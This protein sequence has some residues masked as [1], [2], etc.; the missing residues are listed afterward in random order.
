MVWLVSI[1]RHIGLPLIFLLI[2]VEQIGLPLPGY[3]LLIVAG[4]WSVAGGASAARITAVAV[5]ASLIAD[6]GWYAAGQRFGSRVL[7]TMCK[8][9]LEPDSCVHDTERV[10]TRFGTRALLIA[11]FLPGL[12]AV[13]TA[14]AGVVGAGVTGFV[15]YD[16]MGATLWAGSGVLLGETFHGAV[17][18]VF[19]ELGA[20]GRDGIWIV[21]AMI[22]GFLAIKYWRRH[23]FFRQL[24]MSRISV[25]ELAQMVATGRPP[26]IV[27]ARAPTSRLRDGII[28]GAVPFETLAAEP[29]S[30]VSIGE[31]VVYCAC[32]NDATAARVAKQL[33]ARGFKPVRPLQGGIHA[34]RDAGYAVST[35]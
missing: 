14:M 16:T 21:L 19:T 29:D 9:S 2:L 6:L 25:Q 31:V 3:T 7:R 5:I 32:P 24:R 13:T 12:G 26:M 30:E 8:L 15:V 18:A 23:L 33:L 17:D 28:P 22:G 20:L 1:L 34:W 10:F 4:S 27:D 35:A 11:K